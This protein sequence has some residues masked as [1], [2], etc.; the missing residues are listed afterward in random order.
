MKRGWFFALVLVASLARGADRPALWAERVKSVVAVDYFTQTEAER[1]QTTAYGVAIDRDG[2]IILPSG[3]IDPRVALAQL[4]DFRVYLPGESTGHSCRYLG[5]DAFTGWHFLRVDPTLAARLVPITAWARPGRGGPRLGEG[6]WGIALR[7]KEED[8]VPYLLMSDVA[9]VQNLPQA[10]AIAQHEVAGPGLP[11]FDEDGAFLGLAVSS[12]GQT[13]LQFSHVDRDG[14]PIM[15]IDLEESS[16]FLLPEEVLPYL[17]RVPANPTGRPV[18]WL[19]AAGFQAMDRDVAEYLK[20]PGQSAV[21]ASEV[22]ENSPAMKA[23]MKDH[24][25]IVALDGKV[26]PRFRPDRIAVDYLEREIERRRPGEALAITVLR[27]ADRVELRAVLGEEPKLAREAAKRYFEGIG[28][29]VREFVYGDAVARRLKQAQATGVIVTFVKPNS[30]AALAGLEADDWI[31]E[32]DGQPVR[33]FLDAELRLA[34]IAAD[35]RRDECVVLVGRGSD[36]AILRIK[37][38]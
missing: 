15:L 26:L 22:L 16:A 30:P 1:R 37:L 28:F 32:I 38:R 14:T 6:V 34:T 35:A 9:L 29:T 12:F 31:K 23:G 17:G 3:A 20:I 5:Q 8:F 24:D 10:T 7:T 21:V 18:A 36:T 33:T 19:G 2:T 11:V 4:K 13:Y 25:I 27:G